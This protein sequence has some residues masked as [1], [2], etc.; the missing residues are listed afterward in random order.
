[1]V[2][3]FSRCAAVSA[4]CS[5]G[6]ATV[7]DAAFTGYT[8]VATPVTTAGQ[9]LIRYEVFATFDGPN[10]TV[11]N[12][13]NFTSPSAAAGE[14]AYG[15]FWHK[16]NSDYSGGVL[17]QQ[18]G[19]WAPQLTGGV[20]T[21]RPFDSFLLIGG[22]PSGT[23]T[24]NADPSWGLGGSGSHAGNS[25]GW[26]RADLVN[27]PTIGWFNSSP[28]NDQGRVGVAPNTATQVKLG[29]FV[30]S[31]NHGF[32]TFTLR[33]AYNTG[34]GS[35]AIFADATFTLSCPPQ[36]FYRDSDGDGFGAAAGDTVTQC[37]APTGYVA[38]NT[39]CD[40][41]N[42]AINPNTIWYRDL[43]G[44]GF[45]AAVDGTLTQCAQPANYVLNGTDNCPTIANPS[46]ADC[47]GNGVGDPCDLASGTLADCDSDG[48]LDICEGAVAINLASPLL[49]PFGN[50]F[51]VNYTF[52]GLPRAYRGTPQ[53]VFEATS[54]LGSSN[55][56]IS[57]SIDGGAQ[58]FYFVAGGTDC[59]VTPD[60]ETKSFTIPALNA[61]VADGQLSVS[62]TASGT[63][64]ASQCAGGGIRVRL[65][66]DGLPTSADC[67]NNGLLDSCEIGTG[68]A[69]DCNANGKP[70]SC[71]LA[72][73][74]SIDCNTNGIPDTCDLAAGTSTDLNGNSVPDECS[75]EFIVGGSGFANIAAAVAAAPNGATIRVGPGTYTGAT[76]VTSKRV[77]IESIAGAET[78]IFSG[79]GL[80]TSILSFSSP[81]AAN[82][83]VRGITFRDGRVGAPLAGLRVG[84]AISALYVPI[85]VEDCVF[86]DNAAEYGGAFYAI[87]SPS[88][89]RDC[90]FEGNE[91]VVDGGA[92][93]FG[94]TGNGWLVERCTFTDNAAGQGGAA[95]VWSS[96][97]T[98][99]DCVFTGNI[100]DALGGGISWY[101]DATAGA[102][103]IDGSTFELNEAAGGGAIARLAGTEAFDIIDT[104]MCRNAPTNIVGAIVDL[105]GNT[106]SQDCNEN[107]ICDADEIAAGTQQDCNANGIPDACDLNG[108]VLAW[109]DNDL[110]QLDAPPAYVL[111]ELKQ[112]AA[113]CGHSLALRV[114]GTL[115]AWGSDAFGQATVPAGL[116]GVVA[117]AAGCDH[118][119]A[120]K[121]DGTVV[122]WGANTHNQCIVPAGLTG[123]VQVAAG[124]N[125]TAALR[126]DGTVVVWGRNASGEATVPAGL[127]NVAEIACG[128]AHTVARRVDG[129]VVCW[130]LN[131]LA[132][133]TVPANVGTLKAIAAGCYH[134]VGL[135]VDGTVIAWGSNLFGERTVPPN[136]TNVVQI[137]A[138]I[139]LHT[140]ALKADGSARAWGWNDFDQLAVPTAAGPFAEVVAGGSH[141]M[142]R[143][144][145]GADC[146]DNNLLDSCEIASGALVD[147]DGDG[148]PDTCEIAIDPTLDCNG[149]GVLNS[150]EIA[151]GA[152]DCNGNGK[153]DSCDLA[154]GTSTD[155]DGNGTIDECA[156]EF[157]VGGS[158]FATIQA[159]INAAPNGATIR[160]AAGVYGP[161]DLTGR[162]LTVRSLGGA[163]T[164]IIDGGESARC[165]TLGSATPG[166]VEIEGFT[167]RNGRANNGAGLAATLASPI[168]RNCIFES[169]IATGNGGAVVGFGGAAQFFDCDFID[170]QALQGGAIA[171]IGLAESGSPL[172]L[173]RC[174]LVENIALGAGGAVYND[175]AIDF[176][177]CVIEANVAGGLGGGLFTIGTAPSR[178]AT[179][180]VCRNTPNNT[181]GSYIDL[182]GNIFSDDCNA[183]GLCD[184]DEISAGTELDCNMNGVP[185]SCEVSTGAVPDCN[186][187]GIPD[188]CDIAGGTSTDI[189]SNG[190]PDD[191]K[192]DCDNDGLPDAWELSQ[193]LDLDCNLNATIDRCEIAANPALDCDDDGALDACEITANPA[194]D[195]N[196][197]GTLDGCEIAADPALDCN[198]NG[199]LDT[200]DIAGGAID[201]DA[202]GRIDTCDIASGA[203][204]E[205]ANGALDT[206]E[207]ARGDLD[208]DGFVSASDLAV[209]LVFW[210]TVNPPVGDLNGDG[211]IN[212]GDLSTLLSN[213]GTTP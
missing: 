191:C 65:R 94:Y 153:P 71:D 50:G 197:N 47:N 96:D 104:R 132:Q 60:T 176:A 200:C 36:I 95:H 155:L 58:E 107:G 138:G 162:A 203:E 102:V 12:V 92:V 39:D 134:T 149:N 33:T 26:S 202:N 141:T 14:D 212:A 61:L 51:P 8:V 80:T 123:V 209:L 4:M 187:N 22:N 114:D 206:C 150:C 183:N 120:L 3:A 171:A 77:N 55:E 81:E 98:F 101:S 13:F 188:S 66:Y 56:F 90:V 48:V 23:N 67:N 38:N 29:Q 156:G 135:R 79:T 199:G 146:N 99:R 145:G 73:G 164:T 129:T 190:I 70:D 174:D 34:V 204:D 91:A 105:G 5:L 140:I 109:G 21:N 18:Y 152:A 28:P 2:S 24:T 170:N 72:A 192:P 43:D 131:N 9:S 42:A 76:L 126:T 69:P 46:Q 186:T 163:Q 44:D 194:L 54:D 205:N 37:V 208:L 128:G 158:G 87:T 177:D 119:A 116:S 85:T 159:A 130:G 111:G 198:G 180:R 68:S 154:A 167:I 86:I 165:I 115:I 31:P 27:N 49:A 53:L 106:F 147:C 148:V 160:V 83:T 108:S 16:D 6:L 179:T 32:R 17:G 113:G 78:T 1:M 161:I 185:D 207:L 122:C 100:A 139:G 133:T 82:S 142:A 63:V 175:G 7:A 118:N 59:P 173:E 137:S 30:L 20:T 117:I 15:G 97:G 93:E 136:L 88:I 25:N 125:H 10:D 89:V 184:F 45:G 157:V 19:T 84:G 103:V 62:I 172:R 127:A 201:C 40:D 124:G 193:G 112:I 144:R 169:N 11:L 64:D 151:A 189:D 143:T 121:S 75:G 181:W 57:V 168:V 41:N 166:A 195:C 182:G 52:T 178:L 213:W 35:G 211:T 210:G 196:G 110:G 74:T